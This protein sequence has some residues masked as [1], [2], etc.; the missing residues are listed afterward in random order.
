[1]K[2]AKDVLDV[3]ISFVQGPG[4]KSEARDDKWDEYR[5]LLSEAA[6][7]LGLQPPVNMP[8]R[9]TLRIERMRD[10]DNQVSGVFALLDGIARDNHARSKVA[11]LEDDR[12]VFE[13][14][15]Y[16]G[17]WTDAFEKRVVMNILPRSEL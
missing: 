3:T 10:L 15:V 16:R 8:V 7:A 5:K 1:M 9:L 6:H 11:L 12:Q 2:S 14:H 4:R 17:E 13:L